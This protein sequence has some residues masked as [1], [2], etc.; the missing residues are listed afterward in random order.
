MNISKIM[1]LVAFMCQNSVLC[2]ERVR[3]GIDL[4]KTT[5]VN[6]K[7]FND[8]EKI[9]LSEVCDEMVFNNFDI[10]FYGWTSQQVMERKFLSATA[11][12]SQMKTALLDHAEK[13]QK[14]ALKLLENVKNIEKYGPLYFEIETNEFLTKISSIIGYKFV[15]KF[16]DQK[17][18]ESLAKQYG[19][20]VESIISNIAARSIDIQTVEIIYNLLQQ[21]KKAAEKTKKIPPF[22]TDFEKSVGILLEEILKFFLDSKNDETYKNIYKKEEFEILE[23][24]Y[25]LFISYLPKKVYSDVIL[26]KLIGKSLLKPK[27]FN[28]K[29]FSLR[30]FDN[31]IALG[32]TDYTA[33]FQRDKIICNYEEKHSLENLHESTKQSFFSWTFFEIFKNVSV[34]DLDEEET[35]TSGK[36][37]KKSEKK[38]FAQINLM[39]Y[40]IYTIMRQ[41]KLFEKVDKSD[42]K[43]VLT[44]VFD[45]IYKTEVFN[46]EESK[47]TTSSTEIT[48]LS[49]NNIYE[50]LIEAGK[51]RRYYLAMIQILCVQIGITISTHISK[52]IIIQK[53]VIFGGMDELLNNQ[54][55]LIVI[56]PDIIAEI[57]THN[58][59]KQIKLIKTE[60]TKI[61]ESSEKMTIVVDPKKKYTYVK[62]ITTNGKMSVVLA[63]DKYTSIA[64]NVELQAQ[65]TK[66]IGSFLLKLETANFEESKKNYENLF[67]EI[68]SSETV[69]KRYILR[70]LFIKFIYQTYKSDKSKQ[71]E[72]FITDIMTRMVV[73]TRSKIATFETQGLK[74][75][76]M[77]TFYDKRE[78]SANM[79][80]MFKNSASDQMTIEQFFYVMD[81]VFFVEFAE[82]DFYTSET[83]RLKGQ[84]D[85]LEIVEQ[86]YTLT[87]AVLQTEFYG[88]NGSP[89]AK[90]KKEMIDKA[91]YHNPFL[92]EVITSFEYFF[93]FLGFFDFYKIIEG[94]TDENEKKNNERDAL[95]NFPGIHRIFSTFY[96]F[97]LT[98]R[99]NMRMKPQN[100][101]QHLLDQIEYCLKYT[102]EKFE[103]IEKGEFDPICQFSHRKYAELYFFYII[104]LDINKFVYK[105]IFNDAD[106]IGFNTHTR[107]FIVF[108]SKYPMFNEFLTSHCQEQSN[109]R[110]ICVTWKI[111]T[112]L[113]KYVMSD[114]ALR[115]HLDDVL[116]AIQERDNVN[117]K[118]NLIN[119]L[120]AMRLY[121]HRGENSCWAKVLTLFNYD[122]KKQ[123]ESELA[124]ILAF[125]NDDAKKIAHYLNRT[126]KKLTIS[127]NEVKI[128]KLVQIILRTLD[129]NGNQTFVDEYLTY[130]GQFKPDFLKIFLQFTIK[131]S[132]YLE[133]A[134]IIISKKISYHLIAINDSEKDSFFMELTNAV[135][136]KTD[137]EGLSYI[138]KRFREKFAHVNNQCVN[139]ASS[140]FNNFLKSTDTDLLKKEVDESIKIVEKAQ[141]D[142]EKMLKEQDEQF[143]KSIVKSTID[144]VK[145]SPGLLLKFDITTKIYVTTITTV[146]YESGQGE[147]IN[148]KKFNAISEADKNT[149]LK[150][151]GNKIEKSINGKF[152]YFENEDENPGIENNQ[153]KNLQKLSQKS[154]SLKTEK[155]SQETNFEIMKLSQQKVSKVEESIK[156]IIDQKI[157]EEENK[158][159][160]S[161]T[162]ETSYDFNENENF[163]NVNKIS[164]YMSNRLLQGDSSN[165]DASKRSHQNKDSLKGSMDK[166]GK[167]KSIGN[168]RNESSKISGSLRGGRIFSQKA[169]YSHIKAKVDSGLNRNQ[170]NK[171]N[172]SS[173]GKTM[174]QLNM[175]NSNQKTNII[176]NQ[177]SSSQKALS[178]L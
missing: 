158:L 73:K 163:E 16:D 17:E 75:F 140:S 148:L 90:E 67:D 130:S 57:Q 55:T 70:S 56:P 110:S 80:E 128:A 6:F 160:E 50:G 168:F 170:I 178:A 176:S 117:V 13:V 20:Y 49:K 82:L 87:Q 118:F 29:L 22:V 43:A 107:L 46:P 38:R 139:I 48:K 161:K 1:I 115:R 41:E 149:A 122:E 125:N 152:S 23:L 66:L 9:D 28:S 71:V 26:E 27:D 142:E 79:L 89:Q 167:T 99:R 162:T 85:A 157:I 14:Y 111:F 47:T 77:K 45:W 114:K 172:S 63:E 81:I 97:M 39:I 159:K 126:Y 133:I 100:P 151:I 37:A 25:N 166:L 18:V 7:Y 2:L 4:A 119:G 120:E 68:E 127:P 124:K 36:D 177:K 132:H 3:K 113:K 59:I 42:K 12:S 94:D 62:Q 95:M 69:G 61:I 24:F 165:S 144:G 76:L 44:A 155:V 108:S 173:I 105:S 78:G 58:Q 131:Q 30:F 123:Q 92:L 141:K 138:R 104:Y 33:I 101:R 51:F 91:L 103:W 174:T 15:N 64:Y 134:K 146:V 153:E 86:T 143:E 175:S 35:E 98:V 129:E 65:F 147:Q 54:S 109:K 11:I 136:D 137:E 145:K 31:L 102:E 52:V 164:N 10:F 60:I 32:E 116:H 84:T 83:A 154:S 21:E 19:H 8:L 112:A 93:D 171:P 150:S 88:P 40:K 72:P 121:T 169:D 34:E 106:G 5:K 74:N 96:S 53:V 135:N 156:K